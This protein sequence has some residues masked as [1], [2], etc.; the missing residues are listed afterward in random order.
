MSRPEMN[1]WPTKGIAIGIFLPTSEYLD[2]RCTWVCYL[3]RNGS[4]KGDKKC[5]GDGRHKVLVHFHLGKLV[6]D[7]WLC[8]EL[9]LGDLKEM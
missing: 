2:T 9:F 5:S 3:V 6:C 8:C 1:M 7:R 4:Q